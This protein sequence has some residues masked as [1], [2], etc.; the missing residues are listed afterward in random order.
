MPNFWPTKNS[1]N[2]LHFTPNITRRTRTLTFTPHNSNPTE[3]PKIDQSTRVETR[4]LQTTVGLNFSISHLNTKPANTTA[5]HKHH[6][7]VS[8]SFHHFCLKLIQNLQFQNH[9]FTFS[10]TWEL[11]IPTNLQTHLVIS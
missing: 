2:T 11:T 7:P 6:S 10:K 5:T 9:Q 4:F 3:R 1:K 8:F